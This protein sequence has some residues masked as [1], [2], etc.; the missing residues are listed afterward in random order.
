M[1]F[2]HISSF[3]ERFLMPVANVLGK[4]PH[5]ISVRNGMVFTLPFT[6]VGSFFLV[7]AS[8]PV[9]PTKL[10]I[11][12][13]Y[14]P[15]LMGWYNFSQT[16]NDYLMMPYNVTMN[17][18]SVFVVLGIAYSL[19]AYRKIHSFTSA[20][21][22][23]A[24][25]LIVAS[26]FKDGKLDAVFFGGPGIVTAILIGLA[27]VEIA[28]FFINR[29]ITLKLPKGVP[30]A[31][32][33]AFN[34]LIPLAVN[35]LVWWSLS[36]LSLIVLDK[37]IPVLL[38][39]LISPA[40]AG[41]DN[42]IFMTV[43][44]GIAQL[45]WFLG[46]HD[47]ATVY[48]LLN[49]MGQAN[50]LMNAHSYATGA[51]MT[52]IYTEPFWSTFI[53]IGGSGSTF[54]FV[55]L[56]IKSKAKHMKQVGRIGLIPTFFNINEPIIFGLPIFLNPILFI[57]FVIAPMVNTA[58]AYTAINF[59]LIGHSFISI[60]WSTPSILS[61]PLSSL[62]YRNAIMTVALIVLDGFIYYPFFK[63]ME[64]QQLIDEYKAKENELSENNSSESNTSIT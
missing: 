38:F 64:K 19:A 16:Y 57:P 63:I 25:F 53:A 29:N 62:D 13:F 48:P 58:L 40:M 28:S 37:S 24:S 10:D 22:A 61:G 36:I 5:L 41:I 18:L 59:N 20:I 39:S 14:A 11:S 9:D 47:T 50:L 54:A 15:L 52:A 51:R 34:S 31:I 44:Y 49:P 56:L 42:G 32:A 7:L 21:N 6:V 26:G 43:A 27:S 17:I 12:T 46:I 4:Q 60:P 35:V 30:D 23:L 55:C 33:E 8:P 3:L 45:F 1:A 2:S